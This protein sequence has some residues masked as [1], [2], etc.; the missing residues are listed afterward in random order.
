[1]FLRFRSLFV[2][3]IAIVVLF[4]LT[5]RTN[6]SSARMSLTSTQSP[7]AAPMI[8]STNVNSISTRGYWDIPEILVTLKFS[9]DGMFLVGGLGD[10]SIQFWNTVSKKSNLVLKGHTDNINTVVF[11]PDDDLLA[12]A[13]RDKTVR[14]WSLKSGS[15]KFLLKGHTGDIKQLGFSADGRFLASSGDIEAILWDVATG[16]QKAVLKSGAENTPYIVAFSP[17]GSLLAV[18]SQAGIDLW[19]VDAG[20]ILKT[21][22]CPGELRSIVISPN[23]RTLACGTAIGTVHIWDLQTDKELISFDINDTAEML[24]FDST[25]NNIAVI[26][27]AISLWNIS[28]QKFVSLPSYDC[29]AVDSAAFNSDGTVLAYGG[30]CAKNETGFI[31]MVDVA[32]GK[33]LWRKNPEGWVHIVLFNPTSTSFVSADVERATIWSLQ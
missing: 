3:S 23:G 12:S 24:V 27:N 25:A 1:M 10:N 17:T 33:E 20:K 11:S 22:D 19:D 14:L 26:G 9:P 16:T 6:V 28:S 18:G 32:T 15:E 4:A 8:T 2:T 31:E 30:L 5:L 21:L 7:T 13:S 29:N